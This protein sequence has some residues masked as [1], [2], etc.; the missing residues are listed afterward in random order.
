MEDK[1][2]T[3]NFTKYVIVLLL[4]SILSIV[5]GVTILIKFFHYSYIPISNYIEI[6]IFSDA[7]NEYQLRFR[8][9]Q[10]DMQLLERFELYSD[11]PINYRKLN[12]LLEN[13]FT[14]EWSNS[15]TIMTDEEL[16]EYEIKNNSTF[17][18]VLDH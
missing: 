5:I 18:K 16:L 17:K 3:F 14:S 6:D 13:T 1:R 8:K 7:N 15:I 4:I 12:K 2:N 10:R 11:K 9:D